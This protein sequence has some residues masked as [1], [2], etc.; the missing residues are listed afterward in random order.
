VPSLEHSG[1]SFPVEILAN[2]PETAQ[3]P[4]RLS[5]RVTVLERA[6]ETP[7]E[8]DVTAAVYLLVLEEPTSGTLFPFA[9]AFAVRDDLLLTS[10][11][12]VQELAK[13]QEK[14]MALLA[15]H[16][17]S[18][19]QEEITALYLEPDY[20]PLQDRPDEQIYNDV[21]AVRLLAKNRDL[22]PL[23]T[24]AHSS[25]LEQGTPLRCVMPLFEAEP[26]TRFDNITPT[27]HNAKI[28]VVTRRHDTTS[29]P[30]TC[31]RLLSLVG[32]LPKNA[33]GSPLINEQGQVVALYVEKA[34]L[35][36][37]SSLANL[38]DRYHYALCLDS[39]TA[40]LNDGLSGWLLAPKKAPEDSARARQ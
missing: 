34:D 27:Y 39:L 11:A 38:V 14:G 10:G 6:A 33:Y 28:Y 3:S 5:F 18:Q 23:A 36:N 25:P 13:A 12:V 21:G 19:Q 35:S 26:L 40:L 29:S 22:M 30:D 7:A 17:V 32:T 4:Q 37:N 9:V 1:Q 8:S 16:C 20:A 24:A 2:D 15:M 31:Y